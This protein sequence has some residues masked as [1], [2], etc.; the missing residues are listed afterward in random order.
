MDCI[1]WA[2]K[3]AATC[4]TASLTAKVS[5]Q[6]GLASEDIKHIISVSIVEENLPS[7]SWPE[8]S[9]ENE[10][11][12]TEITTS[13]SEGS[14]TDDSKAVDYLSKLRRELGKAHEDGIRHRQLS[15]L[16]RIAETHQE[17]ATTAHRE[18]R[19]AGR[20]RFLIDL[21]VASE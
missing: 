7:C 13:D 20:R 12:N 18:N 10:P 3:I 8:S 4:T 6:D 17:T 14:I 21:G 16:L 19:L 9:T 2:Q 5:E 15:M 1:V 11:D